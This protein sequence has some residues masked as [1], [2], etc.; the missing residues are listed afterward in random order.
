MIRIP[1]VGAY[2]YNS[3]KQS[4]IFVFV[5]QVNGARCHINTQVIYRG[6]LR[7]IAILWKVTLN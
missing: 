4:K 5:K 3:E 6:Y 7:S 2:H 1:F